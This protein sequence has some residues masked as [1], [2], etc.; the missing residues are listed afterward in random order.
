L[1]HRAPVVE[2]VAR[3]L[4]VVARA[5]QQFEALAIGP[6]EEGDVLRV[7]IHWHHSNGT[8]WPTTGASGARPPSRSPDAGTV[9]G[10]LEHQAL[11][12]FTRRGGAGGRFNGLKTPPDVPI[13][14]GLDA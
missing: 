3:V 9:P 11:T 5:L 6:V 2:D 7:L 14:A 12:K 4:Q 10:I 13:L 1:H 8:S